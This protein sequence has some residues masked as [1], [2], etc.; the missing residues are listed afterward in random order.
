M[1]ASVVSLQSE[2]E[3]MQPKI[4]AGEIDHGEALDRALSGLLE[5][6]KVVEGLVKDYK[7]R[8]RAQQ[9]HPWAPL[10]DRT[11]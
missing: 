9:P 11:S 4:A 5:L 8:R 2:L 3:A 6:A 7:V 10:A 1:L